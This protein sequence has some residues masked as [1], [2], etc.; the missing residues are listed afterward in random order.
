M[1]PKYAIYWK[2]LGVKLGLR[3]HDI[4]VISHNNAYNP[5]RTVDCCRSMFNKW[6]QIDSGATWGK[7]IDAISSVGKEGKH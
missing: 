2:D 4:D 1:V 5:N 6:L 3:N 7:L